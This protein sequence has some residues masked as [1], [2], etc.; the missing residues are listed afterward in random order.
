MAAF[1]HRETAPQAGH[2]YLHPNCCV[3][4]NL[5][6]PH[7]TTAKLSQFLPRHSQQPTP[8]HILS[9]HPTAAEQHCLPSPPATKER[10]SSY[11]A[12]LYYPS[13]MD[14][15]EHACNHAFPLTAPQ[16]SPLSLTWQC[17]CH[18]SSSRQ[19]WQQ[20]LRSRRCR[21]TYPSRNSS[22]NRCCRRRCCSRRHSCVPSCC[23][24]Y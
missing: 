15:T 11:A 4:A 7:S 8:Q 12:L 5:P 24:P 13:R 3:L 17:R 20:Q 22:S 14:L 23:C 16:A 21:N 19:L 2:T 18:P 9:T 1:L 10:L 6:R